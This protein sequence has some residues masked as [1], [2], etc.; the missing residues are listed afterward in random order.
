[1]ARTNTKRSAL[2]HLLA[3]LIIVLSLG[4]LAGGMSTW[5]NGS[6]TPRL[7]LDLEGGTEMVLE[8]VLE[9]NQQVSSGQ[10]DQAVDIIRQRIDANGVS[11]A[12]IATQGGKNIVVSIPGTPTTE[13]LDAIRKPSQLRFRPVFVQAYGDPGAAVNPSGA[14]TDTPTGTST[15]TAT[16]TGTPSAATP[17]TSATAQNGVVPQ[18]LHC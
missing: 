3:L 16:G 2:R 1:M 9:N 12:E 17:S 8:P 15:G 5:G 6:T 7:G 4:A 11:E 13:Q 14:P 10:I 18:A